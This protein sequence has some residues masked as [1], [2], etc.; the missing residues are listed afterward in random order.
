MTPVE[1]PYDC[2]KRILQYLFNDYDEILE[3]L[4][5][6]E[7]E[8]IYD[9]MEKRLDRQIKLNYKKKNLKK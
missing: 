9:G 5:D 2:K 7:I 8:E 1:L 6:E 4:N 3:H